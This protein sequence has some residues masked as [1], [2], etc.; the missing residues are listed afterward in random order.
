MAL[1]K[2]DDQE[3]EVEDGSELFDAAEEL[4]VPFGCGAGSCGA[5]EVQVIAGMQNLE[6]P[7]D[8]EIEMDLEEG[9]R[10][11]CQCKIISGTVIIDV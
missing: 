4:G 8:E 2:L 1:L 11:M 5:C 10:L 6:D 7:T 3:V 9:H